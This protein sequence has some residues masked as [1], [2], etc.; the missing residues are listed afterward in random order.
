MVLKVPVGHGS[1]KVKREALDE[2]VLRVMEALRVHTPRI[3]LPYCVFN[4]GTDAWLDIGNKRVGVE[5]LQAFFKIP[6]ANCLHVGDQVRTTFV[7]SFADF[8]RL[9]FRSVVFVFGLCCSVSI[10]FMAVPEHRQ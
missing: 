9:L 6:Q 4:G 1:S 7:C 2:L 10:L 3:T 5:A 8:C